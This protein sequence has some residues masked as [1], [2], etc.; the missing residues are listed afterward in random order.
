MFE[1]VELLSVELLVLSPAGSLIHAVLV[2]EAV[3]VLNHELP[4]LLV[5]LLLHYAISQPPRSLLFEGLSVYGAGLLCYSP[6][7]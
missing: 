7:E 6:R 1:V 3:I 4:L 5:L 2:S